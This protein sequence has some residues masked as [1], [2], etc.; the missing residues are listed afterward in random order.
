MADKGGGI[1]RFRR[2]SIHEDIVD[3]HKTLLAAQTQ[4]TQTEHERRQGRWALR[5]LNQQ[6]Q[7][8]ETKGKSPKAKKDDLLTAMEWARDRSHRALTQQVPD[9]NELPN[10]G[11]QSRG[12]TRSDI[13]A[14]V[15]QVI[16][17]AAV[18]SRVKK[19][20][21]SDPI[22]IAAAREVARRVKGMTGVDVGVRNPDGSPASEVD[23]EPVYQ[24][25]ISEMVEKAVQLEAQ[26]PDSPM[27]ELARMQAATAVA[28]EMA[29]L[30]QQRF[31]VVTTVVDRDGTHPMIDNLTVVERRIVRG[32]VREANDKEADAIEA[33]LARMKDIAEQAHREGSRFEIDAEV[34]LRLGR[35]MSDKLG[36]ADAIMAHRAGPN[37]RVERLHAAIT[38]PDPSGIGLTPPTP[39]VGDPVTNLEGTKIGR[40][41]DDEAKRMI[42]AVDALAGERGAKTA[43]DGLI[44][45]WDERLPQDARDALIRAVQVLYEAVRQAVPNYKTLPE[46]VVDDYCSGYVESYFPSAT[47]V[48]LRVKF[49]RHPLPS[50]REHWCYICTRCASWHTDDHAHVRRVHRWSEDFVAEKE[51]A[52]AYARHVSEGM[53]AKAMD[54]QLDLIRSEELEL[55]NLKVS[56][57]TLGPKEDDL[58]K[59]TP[60]FYRKILRRGEPFYWNVATSKLIESAAASLPDVTLTFPMMPAPI[61]FMYFE[62]LLELPAAPE[63]DAYAA[64]L[65][66][67]GWSVD[68]GVASFIFWCINSRGITRPG[69]FYSWAF[70]KPMSDVLHYAALD[71]D[72]GLRPTQWNAGGRVQRMTQYL[73]SAL[74][75]MQQTILVS[76]A[77]PVP[78]ATRKRAERDH[79]ITWTSAPM[80]QIVHLRRKSYGQ[81]GSTQIPKE[82]DWQFRWITR[83]HW[84]QQAVGPNHT[85]HRPTWINAHVKGPEGKPIKPPRSRVFA[86]VR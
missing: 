74:L 14:A 7:H 31:G 1:S 18:E 10:P 41:V 64:P 50:F 82:V 12:H 3:L 9:V 70:G 65:R 69:A 57:H 42:A 4:M 51:M 17:P 78:R 56:G 35:E 24:N 45:F 22:A 39:K 62:H 36:I 23:V 16:H 33:S 47:K 59:V 76:T 75:F 81:N 49:E 68:Q 19:A 8:V 83:G 52:Q 5:V 53:Y 43:L 11:Q 46:T 38:N 27:H 72:D 84:R 21:A 37:A 13:D 71:A 58:S 30:V 79:D 34:A 54:L 44:G 15:R 77:V 29:L 28:L 61:G 25:A 85:D 60:Y 66:A 40:V 6:L 86:V 73:A 67:I 2:D 80:I 55:A 63:V 32:L 26:D 20:A 48:V